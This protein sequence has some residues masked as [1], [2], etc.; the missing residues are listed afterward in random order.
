MNT[1]SLKMTGCLVGLLSMGACVADLCP[2]A[3]FPTDSES[4]LYVAGGCGSDSDGDGSRDAPFS[5]ISQAASGASSGQVIAVASGTYQESVTLKAGV[6]LLGMGPDRVTIIADLNVG[7]EVTGTAAVEIAHLRVSKAV[8]V[9]IRSAKTPLILDDV[10]V[11]HTGRR[12]KDGQLVGGHGVQVTGGASLTIRRS[13][14]IDNQGTGV[15]AEG[16]G[17]VGIIA[18]SYIIDPSYTPGP[19]SIIDPSYQPRPID[20]DGVGII[21]PSYQVAN[22]TAVSSN[23]GGGVAIIDPSYT[24][25]DADD[26]GLV[27]QGV[28][29]DSNWGFGV[30]VYGSSAKL[31]ASAIVNTRRENNS[32]IADGCVVAPGIKNKAAVSATIDERSVLASNLRAGVLIVGGGGETIAT[33]VGADVSLNAVGG[34]WAQGK[35]ALLKLHGKARLSTNT[36]I[37]AAV[38]GG[39]RIEAKG[40]R[41][42]N[43]VPTNWA[44]IRS[45]APQ[46]TGADGI[47]IFKGAS[48]SLEGIKLDN[49]ARA[50]VIVDGG[51]AKAD[52]AELD[53]VLKDVVFASSGYG[54]L[55]NKGSP[56]SSAA[57]QAA[58]SKGKD[59]DQ[60]LLEDAQ[61]KVRVSACSQD[62]PAAS[63]APIQPDQG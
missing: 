55:I 13:Q 30:A 15:L 40:G 43:T 2:G 25:A 24:P 14:I 44:P 34:I 18:P 49:L 36:L 7:V 20:G 51:A 23:R 1:T 3:Q 4:A 39:S 21:D 46:L 10:I 27:L 54:V 53:L 47:G 38:T 59:V 29:L 63:C 9:G 17:V 32:D 31:Q 28:F 52:G 19:N 12:K 60:P 48:G 22:S 35:G 26:V 45:G 41:A 62:D 58:V 61:V 57:L 16:A 37:G 8:P 42:D 11:D 50:G 5:T 56:K 33:D 6:R